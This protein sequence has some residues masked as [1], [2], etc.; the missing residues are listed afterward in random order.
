MRFHCARQCVDCELSGVDLFFIAISD[1]KS[2]TDVECSL[3]NYYVPKERDEPQWDL[4][5][6]LLLEKNPES[7]V[8]LDS[9]RFSKL[10][11]LLT[12]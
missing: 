9:A 8:W 7:A 5:Y 2:L 6:V 1:A 10:L 11:L 12:G 4:Y 3:W